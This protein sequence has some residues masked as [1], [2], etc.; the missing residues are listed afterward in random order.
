M[1]AEASLCIRVTSIP[2][3]EFKAQKPSY[4]PLNG[5]SLSDVE[6]TRKAVVN[7]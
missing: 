7:E 3:R 2:T 5:F 1:E 4:L 6:G